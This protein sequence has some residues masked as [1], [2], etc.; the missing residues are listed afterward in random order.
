MVKDKIGKGSVLTGLIAAIAA[1]SCCIPPVLTAIAG[2]SGVSTSFSWM[3]PF[4]PYLIGVA[5]LAIGYAWYMH[6]KPKNE[7]D[8]GCPIEKMKWYQ[9]KGF[10]IGM[11]LFAGLSI[12][13]PYYSSIFFSE[14]SNNKTILV[15]NENVVEAIFSIEGMTCVGCEQH[16]NSTLLNSPGVLEASSSFETGKAQ[17]KFDKTKNSIGELEKSI[18]EAT[19][20]KVKQIQKKTIPF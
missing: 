10:L 6:L 13:F 16:V 5:I 17:V 12:S 8:C 3:E 4:R 20:Y 2:V 1:S 19:G 14:N 11:T 15:P 9:T 18:E 7:D